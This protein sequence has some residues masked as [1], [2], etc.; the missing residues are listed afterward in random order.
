MRLKHFLL[1]LIMITGIGQTLRAAE[2]APGTGTDLDLMETGYASAPLS[3]AEAVS[4]QPENPFA[5]FYNPAGLR[6]LRDARLHTL[7]GKISDSTHLFSLNLAAPLLPGL[8]AGLSWLHLQISD[9]RLV[10]ANEVDD[11]TDLEPDAIA[12]YQAH[13]VV[14][15]LSY[16][17]TDTFSIGLSLTGFY[18][19]FSNIDQDNGYGFTLTPGLQWTLFPGV[20]FGAHIKNIVSYSRWQT[21]YTESFGQ[22][23]HTG[24]AADWGQWSLVADLKSPLRFPDRVR[25]S[26]GLEYRWFENIRF[27]AGAYDTHF[28]AGVGVLLDRFSLDYTYLGASGRRFSDAYRL[29]VGM[30]L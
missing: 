30:A 14:G 4:A 23:L 19:D 27:R 28:N 29:S 18:K 17:L 25:L 2:A 22:W 24:L 20:Y 10:S 1:I 7:Q 12:V 9:I 6:R 11:N 5:G 26:A 15:A 16:D 3:L 8:N 13:G 21:G